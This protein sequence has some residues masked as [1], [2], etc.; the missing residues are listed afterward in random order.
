MTNEEA[1]AWVQ[2]FP[3]AVT[4]CDRDGVILAMNDKSAR[5]FEGDGGAALIGSSLFGCHPEPALTKVQ[6]M[7]ATGRANT[8]TIEKKGI[9]KLI[10]QSPWYEKGVYSGFV[11]LSLE[12]P[13]EIPHFVRGE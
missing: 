5:T 3:G 7:L 10:Y 8:Y 4:V 9:K 12:I 11:E 1:F 2:E 13:F 6:E